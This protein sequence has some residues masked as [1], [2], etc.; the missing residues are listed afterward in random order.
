MK[1]ITIHGIDDSLDHRLRKKATEEGLSIN[2]TVK[3]ILSTSFGLTPTGKPP[4]DH[5]QEFLDLFGVWSQKDKKEFDLTCK[6][7]DRIDPEDWEK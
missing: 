5:R 4:A 6:E 2:K 7:F 3:K 1:S